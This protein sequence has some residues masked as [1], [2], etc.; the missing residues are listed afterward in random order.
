M[1]CVEGAQALQE[2]LTSTELLG[3]SL[4]TVADW[5]FGVT[6]A[7]M[8]CDGEAN[9]REANQHVVEAG[10]LCQFVHVCERERRD[11]EA[12]LV[13]KF[14]RIPTNA[15]CT[16]RE[17]QMVDHIFAVTPRCCRCRVKVP[18][19]ADVSGDTVYCHACG[20]TWW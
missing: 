12:A 4:R 6:L 1:L 9:R 5:F 20:A 18:E 14:Y 17:I 13:S 2:E 15:R 8:V 11:F 3:S 16:E 19:L 10:S 7:A